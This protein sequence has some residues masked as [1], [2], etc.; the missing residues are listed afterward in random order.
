MAK[1]LNSLATKD[2]RAKSGIRDAK[3]EANVGGF[4]ENDHEPESQFIGDQQ[5]IEGGNS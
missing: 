3:T 5:R 2:L 1:R 4:S